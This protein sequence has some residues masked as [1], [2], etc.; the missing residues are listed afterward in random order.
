VPSVG[1][2]AEPTIVSV[3]ECRKCEAPPKIDGRLDDATWKEL[4]AMEDFFQY[5]KATPQPPPLRTAARLCYDNAGLYMGVTLFEERVGK[6]KATIKNRDNPLTWTDDCIEVMIDPHNKAESYMKFV[7]NP[8]EARYEEKMTNG[9]LDS[10]WNV[11]GW[12]VA[13]SKA[14][15]AW[16]IEFFA[17]WGDLGVTPQ[18]GDVWSF[19]LVRYGYSTGSFRGVS[20]SLGG[21]GAAPKSFGYLYFGRVMPLD[22]QKLNKLEQAIIPTKGQL[23]RVL[24]PR[25]VFTH[26]ATGEWE[27]RPMADWVRDACDSASTSATDAAE[28]VVAVTDAKEKNRLESELDKRK[29]RL[30]HLLADAKGPALGDAGGFWLR[31]DV[32]KL[33]KELDELR[34][35]ALVMGLVAAQ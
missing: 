27:K 10:S 3:Y 24:L 6:I 34:W 31:E 8:L 23:F 16:F 25:L 33:K 32:L 13:V 28:A 29:S 19:D 1:R 11:E 14:S 4:P 35:E 15:D 30:S 21:S 9:N 20:W 17:P 12:K 26:T 18:D 7:T 2:A 22:Q 5:W